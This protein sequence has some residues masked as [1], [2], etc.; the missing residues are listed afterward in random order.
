MDVLQTALALRRIAQPVNRPGDAD[1]ELLARIGDAEFVLIGEASHGTHEFYAERARLTRLLIERRGFDAVAAEADWPDAWRVNRWVRHLGSDDGT[2]GEALGGF[3]RFPTWMW[4]N[5]DVLE[6]TGWLRDWNDLHP[7]RQAGFYGLDLYAFHRAIDAVLEYLDRTDPDAAKRARA[8]YACFDV[9]DRDPQKY[10]Y[11]VETGLREPCEEEVVAQLVEMERRIVEADGGADAFHAR[12]S[13]RLVA[14]AE[15]YYR[16]MFRGPAA[17]WNVR[18]LHMQRTLEAL[19]E[20]LRGHGGAGRVVVW[21]HNSHLGDA[22]ATDMRRRREV[23]LGQL[24]RERWGKRAFLIGQTTHHGTVT[25]A[26]DWDEPA[27]RRTVRPALAG[28][29]EQ[30]FH[31]VGWPHFWIDLRARDEVTRLLAA[32]RLQRFIGVIYLPESERLS[33]YYHA[34]ITA[35]YDLLLHH[36]VTHALEPLEL[37]ARWQGGEPAETFPSGL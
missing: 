37:T 31:R 5:A 32:E 16:A 4:R 29:Y 20:H 30:L 23:N 27:L 24:A 13:A 33:H 35:Q 22:R 26:A 7:Q 14:G 3:E 12:Q 28:S 8:R 6:F 11:T 25:A 10:G 9:H 36:D 1:D 21:A 18:D 2:A 34:N 19:V 15:Q 17:S